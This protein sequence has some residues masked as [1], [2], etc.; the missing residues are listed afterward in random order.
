MNAQRLAGLLCTALTVLCLLLESCDGGSS[1]TGITTAQGNV[2]S[3]QTASIQPSTPS[4]LAG[5]WT[6]LGDLLR[7]AT[8]ANARSAVED[9][10]VTIEG[11]GF[12]SRTDPNGLF[13]IRGDF[14]GPV[15]LLFQRPEDGIVARIAIDVPRGG[16]FTLGNL[17]IDGRSEKA[18]ADTRTL[19][20][21][22]LVTASDCPQSTLSLVSRRSPNDGN[23][24][25]VHLG[26][27]EV[28]DSHG[29]ALRCPDLHGG[30]VLAVLGDVRDD[31]SV[32]A[33]ETRRNGENGGNGGD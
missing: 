6:G 24:Y 16:T 31:G 17:R 3:A 23:T 7:F 15:T 30:D 19:T 10:S 21:E 29:N 25:T 4:R 27:T 12:T 28:R 13:S 18:S 22:G 11:T 8:V 9:I 2:A 5:L 33:S 32:D 20:F 1:G 26:S 14:G